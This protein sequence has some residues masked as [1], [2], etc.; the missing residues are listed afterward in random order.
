MSKVGD[1]V[2]TGLKNALAHAKS[3]KV[4]ARVHVVKVPD[5]DVKAVRTKL[6]LTQ[7]RFAAAF[8]VSAKTVRKWE[9]KE[10]RP[11]GPARV[12]LTVIER[13][14]AAVRRA[15]LRAS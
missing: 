15:L 2:L 6:G 4:N 12:L 7:D 1:D 13:E 10:R 5:V 11:T 9:Q 3:E 8:G 14:P